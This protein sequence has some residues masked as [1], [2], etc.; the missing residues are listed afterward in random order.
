MKGTPFSDRVKYV[1]CISDVSKLTIIRYL[2]VARPDT[3]ECVPMLRREL[4]NLNAT[5]FGRVECIFS[6]KIS[7]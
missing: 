2:S 7:R 3:S 1:L 5:K 6:S 4:S